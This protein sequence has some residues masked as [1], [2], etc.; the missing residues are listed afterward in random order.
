MLL[1]KI[2]PASQNIAL[3]E[4]IA[5]VIYEGKYPQAKFIARYATLPSQY[6]VAIARSATTFCASHA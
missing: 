6:L 1:K 2:T 5:T 3:M 4:W